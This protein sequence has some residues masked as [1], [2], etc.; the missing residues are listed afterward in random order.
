MN[1][2]TTFKK[3]V[4]DKHLDKPKKVLLHSLEYFKEHNFVE[5]RKGVPIVFKDEDEAYLNSEGISSVNFLSKDFI[6]KAFDIN[7][8]GENTIKINTGSN[9]WAY[10]TI[11]L[12]AV[13]RV[14]NFQDDPEYYI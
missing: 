5:Y 11:Q 4:G 10:I 9:N 6:G 7:V 14:L 8:L 12:W 13:D 3:Y 1:Y 2:R